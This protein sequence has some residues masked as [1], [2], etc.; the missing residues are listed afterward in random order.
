MIHESSPV[1]RGVSERLKADCPYYLSSQYFPG[2][3]SGEFF[4]NTRCENLED[5]SFAD[6]SIDIHV[7]QDVLEHVFDAEKVFREIS[8]TLK[9]GGAHIFTV[10]IIYRDKPTQLRAKRDEHGNVIHILPA[11]YHSNPVDES[12]SLVVRD[13][14]N[15]LAETI[16]ETT[17][18]ITDRIVMES[19]HKGIKA[20]YLDVF[21]SYKQ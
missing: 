17:G 5:L 1:V 20:E 19:L 9:P 16:Y 4:N 8:R 21:I 10:P 6:N 12:G 15:D 11:E 14:G 7:T 2:I 13:W 3:P 18:M